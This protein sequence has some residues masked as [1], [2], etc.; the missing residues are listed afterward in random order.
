MEKQIVASGK[1]KTAVARALLKAGSGKILIN[2]KDHTTLHSFDFLKI[3]ESHCELQNLFWETVTLMLL[4][5]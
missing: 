4:F 3:E 2:G 1:R 5:K